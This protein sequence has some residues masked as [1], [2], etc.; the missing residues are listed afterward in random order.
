[1]D[2]DKFYARKHN[3]ASSPFE[4]EDLS[5]E[6]CPDCGCKDTR[7]VNEVYVCQSCGNVF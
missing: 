4:E 3:N 6:W 2:V 7:V 1:M 5:H